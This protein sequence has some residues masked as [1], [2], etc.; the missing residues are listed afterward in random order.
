MSTET[1][2]DVPSD[3]VSSIR[4]SPKSYEE[5]AWVLLFIDGLV[6]LLADLWQFI[7]GPI[8]PTP[9]FSGS[10]LFFQTHLV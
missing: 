9:A 4:A 5:Y 1:R 2:S 10:P 8:D 6:F 3:G 7:Q